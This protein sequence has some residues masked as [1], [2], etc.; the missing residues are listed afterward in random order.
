V[1]LQ[2]FGYLPDI[3]FNTVID[4]ALSRQ[5]LSRQDIDVTQTFHLV[6]RKRSEQI[7][8]AAVRRSFDEVTRFE[9]EGRKV[10][11]LGV[12]AA[13]ECNRHGIEHMAVCHPSRRGF[14][15]EQNAAEIARAI[16]R[17]GFAALLAEMAALAGPNSRNERLWNGRSWRIVLKN[18]KIAWLRKSR[19]C[20]A[21]AISA[22]ARS[23]RIDTK[24][25]DRF[26]GN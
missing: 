16:D 13:A 11:A 8:P 18:S 20:S 14:T 2:T 19:K 7:S 24:A 17:L 26:C 22:A 25:S 5:S 4:A 10:I 23:C 3:R 6:P 15:N 1:T 21:S 9:L 12:I